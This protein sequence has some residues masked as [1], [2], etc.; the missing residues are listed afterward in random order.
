MEKEL[1][2]GNEII[3]FYTHDCSYDELTLTG[4]MEFVLY[5][6]LVKCSA[7]VESLFICHM[8]LEARPRPVHW[9]WWPKLSELISSEYACGSI[10]YLNGFL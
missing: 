5:S 4:P 2:K 6:G 8:L 1:S 7:M 3:F 9:L 10:S